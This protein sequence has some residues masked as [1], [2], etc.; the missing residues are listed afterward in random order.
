LGNET[1][2]G[3]LSQA[4]KKR[5]YPIPRAASTGYTDRL[6]EVADIVTALEAWE[7]TN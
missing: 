5:A 3:T 2:P 4:G 6:W 1:P 7:A